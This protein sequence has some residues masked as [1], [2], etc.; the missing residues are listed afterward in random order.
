VSIHARVH[1]EPEDGD[2]IY[3]RNV[4]INLQAHTAL[5]LRRP[6]RTQCRLIRKRKQVVSYTHAINHT[7]ANKL[8]R[9]DTKCAQNMR[10]IK[11]KWQQNEVIVPVI[12]DLSA[13]EIVPKTL[14][15][16][17]KELQLDVKPRRDSQKSLIL[18]VVLTFPSSYSV[19]RTV[20]CSA[21]W[22][23][24]PEFETRPQSPSL[25]QFQQQQ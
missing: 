12:I 24:W 23:V 4:G 21:P 10:D 5:Q 8:F 19:L 6:S 20:K 7:P 18:Y 16:Q 11:Y 15:K 22:I 25:L 14:A 1:L 13:N 17:L 3:L 9:E 2:S